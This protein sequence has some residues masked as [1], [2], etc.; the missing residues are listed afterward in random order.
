[1]AFFSSLNCFSWFSIF[2][3]GICQLFEIFFYFVFETFA[4]QTS[5]SSGKSD[6]LNCKG[7]F[8][9]LIFHPV[10]CWSI[11]IH[12]F[13]PNHYSCY[14]FELMRT[15]N[16]YLCYADRLKTAISR[17][18]QDCDQWIK[19]QLTPVSSSSPTSS[20]THIHGDVTPASPSNHLLATSFGLKVFMH[21]LSWKNKVFL[22]REIFPILCVHLH[23]IT[24]IMQIFVS[25]SNDDGEPRK[26]SRIHSWSFSL[27][28]K[29]LN[30]Y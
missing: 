21:Q 25:L 30:N 14:Y 3:Q 24:W 16:S 1:M 12:S 23:K 18:T 8:F 27:L 10:L 11:L 9:P 2:L 17:I 4:Q 6:S 20:S 5:N 28:F 7:S 29:P 13:T 19:P 26:T 15:H 22:I